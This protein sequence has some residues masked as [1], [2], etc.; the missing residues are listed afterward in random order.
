MKGD[1]FIHG[2]PDSFYFALV[3]F[4]V[5]FQLLTLEQHNLLLRLMLMIMIYFP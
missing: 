4:T 1:L 5:M 2:V 3:V